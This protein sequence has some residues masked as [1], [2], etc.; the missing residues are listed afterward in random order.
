MHRAALGLGNHLTQLRDE[1]RRITG[2]PLCHP[3][4]PPAPMRGEPVTDG[5]GE[6]ASFLG[7]RAYR[8]R[9]TH[10]D[11]PERLPTQNLAEPPSVAYRAGQ[12]DRLG[13]VRPGHLGVVDCDAA[14]GGQYPER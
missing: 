5:D 8:D 12:A 6:V 14:A 1:S 13:G 7:G 10:H 11:R 3:E 9:I 2:H 4:I